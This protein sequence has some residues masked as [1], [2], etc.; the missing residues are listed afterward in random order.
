MVLQW[1]HP[2]LTLLPWHLLLV[3]TR[4][5]VRWTFGLTKADRSS[6]TCSLTWLVALTHHMKVTLWL[7]P[8]KPTCR[9]TRCAHLPQSRS[10]AAQLEPFDVRCI[11]PFFTLTVRAQNL[12]KW[13]NQHWSKAS[14]NRHRAGNV[15]EEDKR[16]NTAPGALAAATTAPAAGTT[17]TAG[18]TG[19]SVKG[20]GSWSKSWQGHKED[21]REER[22]NVSSRKTPTC[23]TYCC[24]R[25]TSSCFFLLSQAFM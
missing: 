6:V 25:G 1:V 13:K 24:T 2:V 7:Q 4:H 18:I 23:A 9:E 8:G 19:G 21:Q 10:A 3:G 16:G 14:E 11:C 5:A 17:K 12:Q 20:P 15:R 22:T